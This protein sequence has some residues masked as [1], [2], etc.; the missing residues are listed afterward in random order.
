MLQRTRLAHGMRPRLLTA[1][2]AACLALPCAADNASITVS[3]TVLSKNNCK[4]TSNGALAINIPLIDPSGSA[5]A[6][7]S[8]ATSFKCGG[9]SS[10]VSYSVTASD[11]SHS[12]GPGLRRLRHLTTTT[13]F[14]DYTLAITPSSGLAAKN[15]VVDVQVTASIAAAAYQNARAGSYSD[16]VVLTVAP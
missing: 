2:L 16:T 7:G 6:S 14:L 12:T 13:E 4:F 15:A 1:A 11:G 5:T 8:V 9:A 3:A 10:S